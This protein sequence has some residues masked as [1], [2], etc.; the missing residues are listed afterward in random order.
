[1][2]RSLLTAALIAAA[3]LAVAHEFRLGDLR[4]DHPFS[5]PSVGA[6]GAGYMTL[7]NEGAAPVALIGARAD[8]AAKVELHTT[9]VDAQG[10]ARMIEQ[11][12]IE[13]APG[14]TVS[15]APG[16]LHVMFMGLPAPLK[17]GDKVEAELVFD[18][19]VVP[20]EFWVEERKPGEAAHD[21]HGHG[22]GHG[23]SD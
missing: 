3:P 15:F 13:I 17:L 21:H 1:M 4:I 6:T 9:E 11:T 19:G 5:H 18:Q 20:V 7:V 16:G 2:I 8:A 23:P 14:E 12:R 22:A 10:V